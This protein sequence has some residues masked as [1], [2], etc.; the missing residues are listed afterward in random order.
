MYVAFL[1]K[2]TGERHKYQVKIFKQQS[3]KL[4][5]ISVVKF[6]ATGYE[7]YTLGTSDIQKRSYIAR[8]KINEDWTRTGYFSAGFWSRWLLWNKRTIHESIKDTEKRFDDI[9]VFI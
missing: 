3:G 4:L 9:K 8:H 5:P 2:L 1:V 7:D 6:G